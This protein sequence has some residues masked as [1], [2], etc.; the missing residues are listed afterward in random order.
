[1]N[2][3]YQEILMPVPVE[4]RQKARQLL[5]ELQSFG[6]CLVAFSGGI[7]STLLARAGKLVLG[8]KVLAVT[9]VMQSMASGRLEQCRSAAEAIGVPLLTVEIRELDDPCYRA[10]DPMRC[11]YC[12]RILFSRLRAL[13]TERGLAVVVDGTNADDLGDFRP[14]AKAAE[15]FAIR[16]P[17]VDCGFRKSEVRTLARA[18]GVPDPDRPSTTCLSTRIAY[19][20][21]VT[22]ERLRMI[23]A[24]EKFLRE[25]GFVPLRVRYHPGEIARIEVPPSMF[26]RL[27]D[28]QLREEI[29]RALKAAGF[30]FVTLDLEGFR[31]GSMNVLVSTTR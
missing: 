28:G 27:L 10:N 1:M 21:E 22:P 14:G 15:E 11:Y 25:Q 17:L 16:S 6:S 9:A 31:S 3:A 20:L 2:D 26:E 23:D 12:K 7:D 13:A 8:E 18:W 5:E 30:K 24:A 19:G 4:L 29:V